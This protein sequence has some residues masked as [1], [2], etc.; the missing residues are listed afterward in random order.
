MSV[1]EQPVEEW[2][3]SHR[4]SEPLSLGEVE[5]GVLARP[6]ADDTSLPL[7]VAGIGALGWVA[8]GFFFLVGPGIGFFGLLAIWLAGRETPPGGAEFWT[9]VAMLVFAV[10]ALSLALYAV[11]VVRA[12]KRNGRDILFGGAPVLASAASFLLLRTMSPDPAPGFLAIAVVALGVAGAVILIAS[13]ASKPPKRKQSNRVPPRRG[14]TGQAEYDR[15]LRT[16]ERVL[17]IVVKR[18]LLKVDEIEQ[19]GINSLPLGY[20]EELD[21]VDERE[22]RRILEYS[23]LGW[24]EFT[25]SDERPWS[26][27]ENRTN[28]RM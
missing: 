13:L 26:P 7:W 3:R 17:D 1:N 8:M 27:P 6:P 10:G 20:W 24:R 5:S 4:F 12:R 14:P 2:A 19:G 28:R 18:G 21:G 9:T 22:R 23:V 25:A 15:Y 16:R 11:E